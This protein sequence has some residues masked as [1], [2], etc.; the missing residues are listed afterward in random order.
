[1]LRVEYGLA[2]Q[3]LGGQRLQR[4]AVFIFHMGDDL[5]QELRVRS[6]TVSTTD[7]SSRRILS[8]FRFKGHTLHDSV[9]RVERARCVEA[10]PKVWQWREGE[11]VLG[12]IS[13]W[14]LLKYGDAF[15]AVETDMWL[16]QVG[17]QSHCSMSR[18]HC[19]KGF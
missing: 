18:G 6:P 14:H 1:M 3:F 17:S 10:L 12:I 9:C 5:E 2:P 19:H 15:G 8:P 7:D 13:D 16:E 11:R 4:H